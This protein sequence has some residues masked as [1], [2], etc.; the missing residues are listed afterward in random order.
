M[1]DILCNI[2]KIPTKVIVFECPYCRIENRIYSTHFP[3]FNQLETGI[4]NGKDN[5]ILCNYCHSEVK[6]KNQY[7]T[8]TTTR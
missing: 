2:W 7:E 1:E 5:I 8:N 3:C 6:L 4:R